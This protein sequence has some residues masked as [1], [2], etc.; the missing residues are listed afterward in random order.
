MMD[1]PITL[2]FT[3]V[4]RLGGTPSSTGYQNLTLKIAD[5][6]FELT[7]AGMDQLIVK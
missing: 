1:T 3:K 5:G 4:T 6:L 7:G 2:D